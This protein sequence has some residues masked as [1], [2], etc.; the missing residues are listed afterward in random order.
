M[1]ES[2]FI[3]EANDQPGLY[4]KEDQTT[5]ESFIDFKENVNFMNIQNSR[6]E[7]QTS[8]DKN[9]NYSKYGEILSKPF[10]MPKIDDFKM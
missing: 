5:G 3:S 6:I 8:F 9:S 1:N 2:N 7:S 10:D 4:E